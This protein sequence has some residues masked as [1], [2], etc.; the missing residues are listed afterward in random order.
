MNI[1]GIDF[2][3]SDFVLLGIAGAVVIFLIVNRFVTGKKDTEN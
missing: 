3:T 2:N 1:L